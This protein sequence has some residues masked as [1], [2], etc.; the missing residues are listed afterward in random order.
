MIDASS[1]V[2]CRLYVRTECPFSPRAIERMT[3]LAEEDARIRFDIQSIDRGRTSDPRAPIVTPTLV[4][5]DGKRVTGTPSLERLRGILARFLGDSSAVPNKVWFLERNRL[6]HGVPLDEI[7][8]MEIGTLSDR[9]SINVSAVLLNPS[10]RVLA[11]LVPSPGVNLETW[12]GRAAGVVG[13][14][15]PNSELKSDLITV[16]RLTPVRLTP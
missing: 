5:P 4:L 10:G 8:K 11:Y 9:V 3:R 2:R 12:V 13:P 6:F 15:T 16:N 7:V 14:R 1:E